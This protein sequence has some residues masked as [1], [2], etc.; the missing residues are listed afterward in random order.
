MEF[1]NQGWSSYSTDSKHGKSKI[2]SIV[3]RDSDHGFRRT[4]QEEDE[5][6]TDIDIKFLE[7]YK[8]SRVHQRL[9]LKCSSSDIMSWVEWP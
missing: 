6:E 2:S 8:A 3:E 1:K 4:T 5:A 9:V 7:K